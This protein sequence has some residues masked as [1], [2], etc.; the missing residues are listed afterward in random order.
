LSDGWQGWP[1]ANLALFSTVDHLVAPGQPFD[2]QRWRARLNALEYP[3]D[4]GEYWDPLAGRRWHRQLPGRLQ[5]LLT[6]GRWSHRAPELVTVEDL[7]SAFASFQ[8]SLSRRVGVPIDWP[9][10]I[11]QAA[12]SEDRRSTYIERMDPPGTG[13]L[14]AFA[15]RLTEHPQASGD[16]LWNQIETHEDPW[17]DPAYLRQ[18]DRSGPYPNLMCLGVNNIYVPG[19]FDG[20]LIG[21]PDH[22]GSLPRL[23]REALHVADKLGLDYVGTSIEPRPGTDPKKAHSGAA[24]NLEILLNGARVGLDR[25]LPVFVEG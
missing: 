21:L 7:R 25:K 18:R 19:D 20:V 9:E 17:K 22:V 16:V 3:E 5:R 11:T 1:K 14:K 13:V 8:R 12:W 24:W 2:F 15:A 23:Q 10:E 4:G 6:K